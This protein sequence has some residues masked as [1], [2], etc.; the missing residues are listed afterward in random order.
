MAT[1]VIPYADFSGENSSARF[2]V[3][4]AIADLTLTALFAATN[5]VTIGAAG[6]STLNTQVNK[7]T[8]PGG[9]PADNGAQRELKWLVRYHDAVTLR[10]YSLEIP[11]PD[12]AL[13]A[14]NT[15]FMDV[16]GGAGATFKTDFEAAV[17]AKI[18]G[19]AVVLD[20]AQLVGRKS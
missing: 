10:K 15:D 2:N 11:C 1:F 4:D 17:E 19:N 9:L 18:T 13:L 3:D 16:T 20:N 5:N 12:T 6:Q 8:G 14:G 7:D